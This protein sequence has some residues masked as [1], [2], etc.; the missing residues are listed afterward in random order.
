[1]FPAEECGW[2][3]R[4]AAHGLDPLAVRE[5]PIRQAFSTGIPGAP[6]GAQS[7]KTAGMALQG[8]T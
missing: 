5:V 7:E 3:K 4:Q 2:E 8:M 1:M 6:G